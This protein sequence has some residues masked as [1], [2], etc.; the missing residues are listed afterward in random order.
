MTLLPTSHKE[1]IQWPNRA[2]CS[3]Y[4]CHAVS[5]RQ[6]SKGHGP[7][8]L[9]THRHHLF[10]PPLNRNTLYYITV[11]LGKLRSVYWFLIFV[12]IHPARS[13][14]VSLCI[15]SCRMSP[16][17]GPHLLS[18]VSS[19]VLLQLFKALCTF[20][21]A[22]WCYKGIQWA[23]YFKHRFVVSHLSEVTSKQARQWPFKSV[24]A[25]FPP[26]ICDEGKA[27]NPPKN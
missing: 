24:A 27:K 3:F 22:S 20:P 25:L 9:T 11:A 12:I 17:T 1:L 8:A 2:G 10:I 23:G 13:Q 14:I 15:L 5:V 19:F 7:S 6:G 16:H 26:G 4:S 18:V 21:G